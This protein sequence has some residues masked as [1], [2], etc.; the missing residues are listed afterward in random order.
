MEPGASNNPALYPVTVFFKYLRGRVRT[1]SGLVTAASA[2]AVL[3]VACGGGDSPDA[4]TAVPPA[5]TE[6]AVAQMFDA[7]GNPLDDLAGAE[8]VERSGDAVDL[9]LATFAHGDFSLK[10][11]E[12]KAVAIN[13][14]FPSC[15]PCRAEL[16]DLQAAYEAHTEEGFEFIGIQ[17][18]GLDSAEDG[19]EFLQE[20][21]IT[22]PNGADTTSSIIR[23]FKVTGFP[24]TVFL[25]KSHEVSKKWT[26][27]LGEDSL[28]REIAAALAR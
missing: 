21:G 5:P 9:E 1:R 13:F 20:L 3:A 16:P 6:T 4:S 11:L 12:G 24:T 10:N 28:D 17:L 22:Y 23:D 15:P 7:Q 25:D 2:I 18:L 19:A 8:V 26:G 14:W 27:I